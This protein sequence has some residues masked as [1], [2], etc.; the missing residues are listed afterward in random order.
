LGCISLHGDDFFSFLNCD[1]GSGQNTP[2][3]RSIQTKPQVE[4]IDVKMTFAPFEFGL[5]QIT[6]FGPNQVIE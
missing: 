6:S 4:A 5:G 3:Y 2:Q 1:L